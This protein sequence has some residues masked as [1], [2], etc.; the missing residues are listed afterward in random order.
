MK[1]I[2]IFAFAL[3]A[4]LQMEAAQKKTVYV[5]Y[6]LHGNMNYDRYVRPTI[7]KEFPYIYD[8]LLTFMD[9]HPDFCGQ[10]QFSGQT[11]SSMLQCSPQ[12]L[13]HAMNIHRRGQLNFTGTFYS[14]PVNVNMDGETNYRCAWLGTKMVEDFIGENTDG[15]YLQERAYHSQ[16]P[17]ILSHSNVSWVPV[18]TSEENDWY[19]FSLVG[20]DG[21]KSVC[22]PITRHGGQLLERLEK[23]PKNSLLLIEEDYE[24]PQSF[25]ST[26]NNLVKFN[27][28]HPDVEVKWITV[29]DYIKKFGTRGE[30]IVGHGAKA[31]NIQSGTYSRWTADPLDIVVQNVTN[32]AMEDYRA[33]KIFNAM[34]R[35]SG[36]AACD[37]PVT[38][39]LRP[40][41]QDP[42]TW[43]IERADLYP[44]IET[45]FLTRDGQVTLLSRAENLL[46]WA[47]NS[48]A[49]GWYPLYEK[50]RERMAA[51]SESSSRSR[52]VIDK[53]LDDLSS[54]MS[55]KG[56]ASYYIAA[57]METGRTS[58]LSICSD[59]PVDVYDYTSGTRLASSS[60][61]T[62]NGYETEFM[63]ALPS[64]GY[65]VFATK[66]KTSVAGATWSEGSSISAGGITVSVKGETIEVDDHGRVSI[67]SLDEFYIKFL[68][69]INGSD[70]E[71]EGDWRKAVSYGPV[72]TAVREG[73]YP[74]LR[75][76][77]QP[78]WLMHLRQTISIIDGKVLLDTDFDFP[79]PVLVR[80]RESAEITESTFDPR[81]MNLRISTGS[82]GVPSYDM[83]YGIATLN[84]DGESH[85]CPLSTCILQ[86]EDYGIMVDARTGEQGM[87]VNADNGDVTVYLGASTT[88]G[89]TKALSIE[90]PTPTST[91][92][93]TSW[94]AEPFH[95]KYHH[96][97][98]LGT[99]NGQWSDAHVG[100]AIRKLATPVYLRECRTDG[101][102]A[103]VGISTSASWMT[104]DSPSVNVTMA[105]FTE[106][107]GFYFRLNEHDGKGGTVHVAAGQ[108]KYDVTVP[109]F[110]IIT[111][112]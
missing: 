87:T 107:D 83:P 69:Q 86:K 53:G 92:H 49:K 105:D 19:P 52:E 90:Y 63:A 6:V 108:D 56:Y 35:R 51:L 20:S 17:W 44:T 29:K 38:E 99:W 24:I 34:M 10:V 97:I 32:K 58:L 98:V 39:S 59:N 61:W 26:Y 28:E 106:S 104:V 41:E 77:R 66:P 55:L 75:I 16:L 91:N 65:C 73:I 95:G 47:V 101:S 80:C 14:E 103:A 94:Y 42:L 40:V 36:N 64:Y 72:R 79:H 45:R 2:L 13:E 7:W 78:D 93:L 4:A 111:V 9:E 57:N 3:L 100:G 21:S 31:R 11:L 81:G 110:G 84:F 68:G 8:N 50:R 76:D 70:I 71:G 12:V 18:I 33:A 48:D 67:L 22:V 109:E 46:L 27:A 82:S 96:T 30:R 54:K 25:V 15:F 5:S 60:K 1:K 62:G 43:N 88:S 85:L 74:Q 112:K 23:A 102:T 89:P 37:I